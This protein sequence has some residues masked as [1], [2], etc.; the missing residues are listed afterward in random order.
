MR[1]HGTNCTSP[2][3]STR[4]HSA[5]GT[6]SAENKIIIEE[7]LS[8]L[9]AKMR[10]VLAGLSKRQQEVIYLRFYMDADIDEIAEIM[11]LHRQSVYN[12]LHDALK[13]LRRLSAKKAFSFS[14]F[15]GS[16]AFLTS[17]I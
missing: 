8:E 11:S 15:F 16:F 14:Q 2:P 4:G 12:L 17:L 9:A 7:E 6:Q 10:Q 3:F 1:T 13:R 5:Q